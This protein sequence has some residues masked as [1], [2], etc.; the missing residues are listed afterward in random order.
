MMLYVIM[1]TF[2]IPG[3]ISLSLLAGALYGSTKG[4]MLIALVSTLGSSSCYAMSCL[5]GSPIARAVWKQK[6][7]DFRKEVAKQ[8]NDML[9]YI[10]FLRV[11]PILPN[12]FINVASPIVGVPFLEFMLGTLIGCAPNNFMAANAGDH[13][14]ELDSLADLYKPRMLLLGLTVGCVALLP[15]YVKHRH[16]RKQ[17]AAAQKDR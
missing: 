5:F 3:T 13:L 9:S 17:A 10:I 8:R 16:A 14:S 4:F 2:A 7:E 15:V 6:L 11:T 1:Q 12:V